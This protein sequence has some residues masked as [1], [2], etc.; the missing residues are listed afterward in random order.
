MVSKDGTWPEDEIDKLIE[1][2]QVKES[3]LI[4]CAL[5]DLLLLTPSQGGQDMVVI[6][7]LKLPASKGG[8]N[9]RYYELELLTDKAFSLY[10]I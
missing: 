4:E 9:T 3:L 5:T 6:T 10:E 1:L 2:W 8:I 7:D